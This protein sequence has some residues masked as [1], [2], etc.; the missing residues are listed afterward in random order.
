MSPGQTGH[1]TGQMGRVPGTDGTHTRGCLA[2]I[3]YVYWFFSFPI[4]TEIQKKS[5]NTPDMLSEQILEFLAS[6]RLGVRKS[7]TT[8]EIRRSERFQNC[9]ANTAGTISLLFASAF[10]IDQQ[11][12]VMK[13]PAVLRVCPM[14]V[15]FIR[16]RQ[17]NL[18]KTV[19]P[20]I[21][22]ENLLRG[23]ILYT[24]TPPT[25]EIPF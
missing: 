21:V 22:S 17:M 13:L 23:Q 11:E 6:V 15:F 24:P 4:Q 12:L 5:R 2:K 14:Y 20:F 3:L 7:G 16:L 10:F 25:L 19:G 9:A 1:I 8:Q 18:H